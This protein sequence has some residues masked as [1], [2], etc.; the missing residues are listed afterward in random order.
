MTLGKKIFSHWVWGR[1]IRPKTR[2]RKITASALNPFSELLP[3]LYY[4]PIKKFENIFIFDARCLNHR[5]PI[6]RGRFWSVER[7][8]IICD[9]CTSNAMGDEHHY[10]FQ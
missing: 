1:Y 10:L 7:D 9:I 6:E 5:I 2:S 3:N 4:S 8:D